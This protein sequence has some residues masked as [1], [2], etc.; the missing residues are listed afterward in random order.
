[1]LDRRSK[2]VL[3]AVVHAH[4]LTGEPVGSRTIAKRYGL[5]VS[6]ATVRNVMADL[7]EMGFLTHPHTS[8]GRLPTD[9]GYRFYVDRIMEQ[10]CTLP[11]LFKRDLDQLKALLGRRDLSISEVLVEAS[12]VLSRISNQ[13]GLVFIPVLRSTRF[14]HIQFISLGAQRMLVILVAE[15]GIVQHRTVTLD[16][17]ISSRELERYG[18]LL[19]SQFA[20]RSLLEVREALVNAMEQDIAEYDALYSEVLRMANK[21]LE[22]LESEEAVFHVE[23]TSNIL[24]QKEFVENVERMKRVFRAFEEKS[25]VVKLLD[26]CIQSDELV[27]VIGEEGGIEE[28]QDLSLVTS[29]C[30]IG[31]SMIGG[32]GIMGPK[33]MDYAALLPLL[34][35]ASQLINGILTA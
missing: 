16:G 31:E 25:K 26:R 23:G 32:L 18:Q 27:V 3:Q 2:E 22:S 6:P 9:K 12:R 24:S 14:Q 8:A 35:E 13:M 4:I 11:R 21:A 19:N 33:R 17:E 20:G 29:R 28:L 1:M 15:G 30:W 34:S 5:G 7:E 10:G